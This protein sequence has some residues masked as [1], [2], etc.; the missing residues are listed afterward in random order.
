MNND[1]RDKILIDNIGRRDETAFEEFVRCYQSK[2][3]N[4]L[5]NYTHSMPDAEEL[6]QDVFIKVWNSATSFKG[7]SKVST[8]I[9]RI[10]VNLAINHIKKKKLPALSIDGYVSPSGDKIRKDVAAPEITQPESVMKSKDRK[11]LI[12]DAIEKLHPTQKMAFVLSKYEG[13][14]YAEIA[15]IMKVS[16][17]AVESLL[18]RA[19]QNLKEFLLPFREKGEI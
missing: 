16:I 3:M 15:E 7:K 4:L 6:A 12:E 17:P 18:F 13:H 11:I 14:S 9:Y 8:W 5:Y 10:A 1:S 19:K 2:I